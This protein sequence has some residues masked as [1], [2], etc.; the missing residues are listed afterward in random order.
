MNEARTSNRPVDAAR[1][2]A[3]LFAA[4]AVQHERQGR[5]S[6][7][8]LAALKE[9]NLFGLMTPTELGGLEASPRET[10]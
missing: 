5:L 1:E 10:L 7:D 9:A 4:K 3:S 6:D 8:A 2:H